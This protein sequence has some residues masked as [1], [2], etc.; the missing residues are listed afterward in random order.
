MIEL[1]EGEGN[2]ILIAALLFI[3]YLISKFLYSVYKWI[4]WEISKRWPEPEEEAFVDW[5]QVINKLEGDRIARERFRKPPPDEP[6]GASKVPVTKPI[7]PILT[8]AD[9]KPFPPE[10]D[11]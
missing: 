4:R 8:G 3:V 11:L 9:A 2:L 5:D 10:E 6:P 1:L 7:S